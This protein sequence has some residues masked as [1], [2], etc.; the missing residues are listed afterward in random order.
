MGHKIAPWSDGRSAGWLFFRTKSAIG[1]YRVG[2]ARRLVRNETKRGPQPASGGGLHGAG[3]RNGTG[4]GP[5][6]GGATMGAS[7]DKFSWMRRKSS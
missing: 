1:A 2:G 4:A 6:D 7:R 3:Q 5:D